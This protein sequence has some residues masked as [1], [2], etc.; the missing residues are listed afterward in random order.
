MIGQSTTK[1]ASSKTVLIIA[2]FAFFSTTSRSFIA[3]AQTQPSDE[4]PESGDLSA[5]K[6]FWD[7]FQVYE[8]QRKQAAVTEYQAARERIERNY[9]QSERDRLQQR[10]S[11]IETAITR[12]NEALDK[13]PDVSGRPYVLLNLAQM[14][15]EQSLLQQSDGKDG[16]AAAKLALS[17]LDDLERLHVNFSR[18]SDAL[19]LKA[20]LLGTTG[21]KTVSYPIWLKL[22]ESGFNRFALHANLVLGDV[23]FD[24]ASPDKAVKYYDRAREIHSKLNRADRGSDYIRIG[25]RLAWATFKSERYD[26]T[27]DAIRNLLTKDSLANIGRQREKIIADIGD[28]AGYALFA[29]NDDMQIKDLLSNK[30]FRLIGPRT[31]IALMSQ[32]IEVNLPKKASGLGNIA[33]TQFSN[34]AEFPEILRL[35]AL[36]DD[37]SGNQAAR[38]EALEKL[39][40]LL[41]EKSLWRLRHGGDAQ[42]IKS[43]EDLARNAAEFVASAYYQEG[44][45]SNSPRKFSMAASHYRILLDDQPNSDKAPRLRLNIGNCEYFA[46]NFREAERLYSELVTALKTPEDVLINAYY[47][48]ALA[49]EKIWRSE[50]E[51]SV[52]RKISLTDNPRL[53]SK[54]NQLQ[55]AV[56]DH[57]NRYPNQSRSVDL[58]LVAAGANRDQNRFVEAS[59]FWQRALLSSPSSGQRAIAVRGL[60]FVKIR[61]GSAQEVIETASNFLKLEPLNE[62]IGTLRK[63]L[64]GV[65]HSAASDESASLAKKGS[66]EDAGTLLL[67]VVSDF[68]DIPQRDKM[69]RDGAYFLAISGNWG[70]AQASAENYLKTR[71]KR[72]DGDMT[73]LL[74]R[75]HEYQLRF[76]EAV[77]SYIQ[78]A[79]RHPNHPRALASLE[80]AEKLAL[81]DNNFALAGRASELRSQLDKNR[82]NS[83]SSLESAINFYTLG[84]LTKKAMAAAERRRAGSKTISDKLEAELL[85]AQIRYKSGDRQIALDDLDTLAKQIE[86]SKHELGHAYKRLAVEANMLL[87]ENALKAFKGIR[88]DGSTSNAAAKIDQKSALFSELA[89]RFDKVASLDDAEMSPKA[90]FLVAQ[91]A[92]DFADEINSLPTRNGEPTGL[93]NQTRFNQNVSRLC[94]LAQ[95]YH[96]N[97][98]LAKQ[99]TPKIYSRSEWI[100]RSALALTNNLSNKSKTGDL[101]S[102]VDQLSTASSTESPVQWSH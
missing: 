4:I 62:T 12:Y 101:S 83:I 36:S 13:A 77:R 44:M 19:Y 2:L 63:E 11:T 57:A 64:L 66:S 28:L 23:E 78:V 93:R 26:D 97:N 17:T 75:A 92:S 98:L 18:I 71:P 27:L 61:S 68:E 35:K 31:S 59:R 25:Y 10:L 95:K 5:Y 41:P 40:L 24:K 94:D 70:R 74:A 37:K 42:L 9:S 82:D 6:R 56:E 43:M 76:S 58:L 30:D 14:Y 54:L 49:F 84:G 69:W 53:I 99:R 7:A 90:R 29:K 52:Q 96:G 89:S 16:G 47:Q 50:F 91:S 15:A 8:R 102:N 21:D 48:R 55:S 20:V 81:A 88:L 34:T 67:Q 80:R 1:N 46:G 65:V 3:N 86:R 32:Y 22:A 33:M 72:F 87:G 39:S 45:A 73:Y 60:V 85:I 38:L 100:S 51:T 79:E